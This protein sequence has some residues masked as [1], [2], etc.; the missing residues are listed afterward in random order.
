MALAFAV[1]IFGT[2]ISV[3]PGSADHGPGVFIGQYVPRNKDEAAIVRLIQTV[4]EGWKRKDVDQIM[5][6]Y[7]PDAVQ[8]AWDNPTVMVNYEGIRKEA[9]GA[10]RDPKIGQIGFEDWVH[11]IYIVNSSAIIE[12]N[13]RFH[14]WGRD[15]YYRDFWMFARRAG[16]WQLVRYD[17]ESQPPFL[18]R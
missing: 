12:I 3:N 6:A 7:A 10:F 4:A 13:Q 2:L 8:R 17:Y 16:R 9:L 18:D 11:R 14:G 5:S 1:F 15:H